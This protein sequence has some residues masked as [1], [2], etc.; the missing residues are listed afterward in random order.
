MN[1]TT[2]DDLREAFGRYGS[3]SDAKVIMDRDTGRS[4]GFAFISFAESRDAEDAMRGLNGEVRIK[5]IRRI[6]F[7]VS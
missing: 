5:R 1:Q 7:V 4:R 2:N 6:C 3:V